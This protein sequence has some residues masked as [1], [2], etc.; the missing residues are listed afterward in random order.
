MKTR[1]G[2]RGTRLARST[3]QVD[4]GA[5]PAPRRTVVYW[6]ADDHS[7]S[8]VFAADVEVPIEWDCRVCS[9]PSSRERGTAPAAAPQRFFPRT[10]YE[11]LMMRRTVADGERILSE[12]LAA[13][14]KGTYPSKDAAKRSRR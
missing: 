2:L 1:G 5:E 11:F 13:M 6:C 3:T 7:T 8:A 14:R 10:P 12:A 4:R 9:G